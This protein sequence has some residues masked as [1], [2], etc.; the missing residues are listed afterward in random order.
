M[1]PELLTF[2]D[3]IKGKDITTL[4]GLIEEVEK[5]RQSTTNEA[6][7]YEAVKTALEDAIN[8]HRQ[9][10]VFVFSDGKLEILPVG[11]YC[12]RYQ[13]ATLDQLVFRD[14]RC[15]TRGTVSAKEPAATTATLLA[16]TL[17]DTYA[18]NDVQLSDDWFNT[19]CETAYTGVDATAL[20][21]LTYVFEWT[22]TYKDW[23]KI[24][25][26][27]QKAKDEDLEDIS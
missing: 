6:P 9:N 13:V 17:I 24:A 5:R 3:A 4:Y 2:L 12:D 8:L 14:E 10:R 18:G 15:I 21:M 22:Y 7:F 16:K 23:L 26:K 11:D 25:R 1:T 20:E 27:I 19:I